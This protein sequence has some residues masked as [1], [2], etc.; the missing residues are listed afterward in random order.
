[1]KKIS[2]IFLLIPFSLSQ[3]PAP[4]KSGVAP[5]QN[6]YTNEYDVLSYDLEIGLGERS[7]EIAGNAIIAIALK[8]NIDKITLD[9]TGLS[10]Q[11]ILINNSRVNYNYTKGKIFIDS[12]K[13]KANQI[14]T[15]NIA[16]SGK[17]DDGLIIGENVHGKRSVFADNWPNRA[18]FWFPSKDHPSDK[19]TVSFAI[20]APSKWKVI[21]NG[22]LVEKP[23]TSKLDAIGPKES[24]RTWKWKSTVPIPT[25][26]MVIGA[27]E[28]DITTLGVA[29]F[30][31]SPSSLRADGSIE[32]SN[33]TFPEDTEKSR[34]SFMRSVEMVN[35]FS[36]KIGPYPYEKLAN[37]QSSTRFGGMENASAIFYSQGA[38]AKGRNIE[39]TVSHEI[40]HQWFGDSVTE[41]EW[42]HLWLSEGFATY[43]GALFFEQ[44][45]GRD[46][47][48]ERM[49]KSKNRILES[50]A[51][52]RPI[53]DYE[54]R[55]LFKLLNSNNYPKGAWVL[56]MLRGLVGDEIFFKGVSKYY[57]Q[58]NNKTALTS[59]FMV[60]ME[61][62]SGKDL[63]YFFDQWIFS[64]GYPI[65]E[66]EQNWYPKKNGKGKTIVTI[67]QTQKKDWPT[68]I[69][70][71]Q[72][73]WDN[74]ECIPI[75]VDQKTQ[76]F[77]IIS[78]MKP[79]SIYIDPEEW[80]L[81][82]LKK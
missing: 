57:A 40:A 18:R 24:R 42:H 27:A 11:N 50:K 13:Y 55:D 45:D 79:D 33:W 9:F 20:H 36:T 15:I 76:S 23:K 75:K 25:Y 16:Y 67:N 82:E 2:I 32:V 31:Y 21:A 37:V 44:S 6:E 71:S 34:P 62:V 39:G 48:N 66:I 10:I 78:S 72:L 69:F 81:K 46:N 59:D 43:F 12:K 14:L 49:E 64:P 53:V 3:E 68:F 51:T 52:N 19:A 70:E 17:P 29:N 47:F 74:N 26:N 1:M 30:A 38:I 8:E 28:M 63:K 54:V 35:F 7:D 80:I 73:C 77:D 56:H 61:E 4:I 41:K 65:I 60:V 22:A 58:Y 5:Y